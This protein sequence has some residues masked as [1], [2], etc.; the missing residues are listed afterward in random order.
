MKRILHG[1][2]LASASV[3]LVGPESGRA[4]D[5]SEFGQDGAA[6]TLQQ[7]RPVRFLPE[8]RD[9]D[10]ILLAQAEG[11]VGGPAI[12]V[13][14]TEGGVNVGIKQ[15]FSTWSDL[16]AVIRPSRWMNPLREGGSLSW[17]NYKAW[18]AAPG[19]TGK[20]ALGEV[21]VFGLWYA[22][23]E[24]DEHSHKS[25]SDEV[26]PAP[27]QE[28]PQENPVKTTGQGDHDSPTEDPVVPPADSTRKKKPGDLPF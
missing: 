9:T 15:E 12:V 8:W 1:I 11:A 3:L 19:R 14:A 2:V 5:S 24:F 18:A 21:A 27:S 20:V 25:K 23:D 26:T 6:V 28:K 13:A 7:E 22:W 4:G 17:L 16:T 10:T